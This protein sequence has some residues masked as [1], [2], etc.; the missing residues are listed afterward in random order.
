MIIIFVVINEHQAIL[1]IL[2]ALVHQRI[3]PTQTPS[4][5]LMGDRNLKREIAL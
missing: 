3:A 5:I 1:S 4:T 2:S